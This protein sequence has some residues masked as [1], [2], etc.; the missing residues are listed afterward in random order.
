[1]LIASASAAAALLAIV[2]IL[3][4]GTPLAVLVALAAGIGL[5]VP[6]VGACMRS[7][8]PSLVPDPSAAR[9]VY[10]AEASAV[11]FTW[12]LG[13]PIALGL[14]ALLS[15]AVALAIAAVVLLAGT[16][17]FAAQ[18]ASRDW[19]AAPGLQR[20]RGGA[21][22]S[23]AM[24]TLVAALVAVGVL[25]GAVE[26]A[27]AAAAHAL[28]SSA[29]A[30]PLLGVW[31]LGSLAGGIL[32][33]RLGG[34]ARSATGLALV[35]AGLT[36]GH[37]AL[38]AAAGSV[39][40]L[41]AVLFVAGAGIAPTF[42]SVYAMVDRVAPDGS[43]TEAFAW[44]ATAIAVGGALGAAAGGAVADSSGPATAF[45]LAGGAGVAAV[46]VTILRSRTLA[47]GAPVLAASP[48]VRTDAP[49]PVAAAA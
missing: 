48:A 47:T 19:R 44:L 33:T 46:L 13:P 6:P 14:A 38:A 3:P 22:R 8:L 42:A 26:V 30:G 29:A 17:A 24:Q 35:L 12:V 36:A 1:M 28:G 11:E 10:A 4:A 39:P 34:G 5:S 18:S 27:V 43:V 45:V 49:V 7:L 21:L 20:A 37:V 41:G 9:A 16:L 2:A 31:G 15:T 40:A 23:P 25:V 32:A